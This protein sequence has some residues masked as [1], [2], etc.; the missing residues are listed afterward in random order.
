MKYIVAKNLYLSAFARNGRYNDM[1]MLE[2]GRG[3]SEDEEHTHFG[4][5]CIMS[6]PLLAGM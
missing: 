5:W 1:D 6:S 3:L 4:L 2:I